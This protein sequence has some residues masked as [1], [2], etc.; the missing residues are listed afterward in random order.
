MQ[1]L[2]SLYLEKKVTQPS[3]YELNKVRVDVFSLC[4]SANYFFYPPISFIDVKTYKSINALNPVTL[5][6]I[7]RRTYNVYR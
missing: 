2:Y 6:R 7:K 3:L 5:Q 1:S 4:A